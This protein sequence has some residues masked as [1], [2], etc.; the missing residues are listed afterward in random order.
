MHN[1]S[2][3]IFCFA[4]LRFLEREEEFNIITIPFEEINDINE[5][6]RTKSQT[7]DGKVGI[8]CSCS[9]DEEYILRWGQERFNEHYGKYNIT[10]IWNWSP[11]SELRPCAT[12]LGHRVLSARNM[13][14][15][16]YNSFLDDTYLVDRKTTIREYLNSYPDI[17]NRLPP[18]ELAERYG[19]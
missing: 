15:K 4:K 6:C 18:P 14:D 2:C 12:Y 9:S 13:G 8:L 19:G 11:S 7:S 1:W 3:S 16:C 5:L 17:M 10:T